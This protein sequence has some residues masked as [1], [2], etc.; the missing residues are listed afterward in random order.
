M[1]NYIYYIIVV[2]AGLAVGS[3]LNVLVL[4]FDQFET[5]LVTRSRCPHCKK[6]IKWY[7]LVPF[8][9]Y[10]YLGAKCR[11]C[12]KPI[13]IQYP[14]VEGLTGLVFGLI[15]W[16]FGLSWSALLLAFSSSLLIAVATYDILNYEMPDVLSYLALIFGLGFVLVNLSSQRMLTWSNFTSYVY[17]FLVGGGF[18]ALLVTISREKWMGAGDIVIGATMGILVGWPNILLGLFAAF[19]AGSIIGLV[20]LALKKKTIKDAVP[21]GLFLVLGT[22][23]AVFWGDKI[24]NWY[25]GIF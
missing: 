4:R 24:V 7:D 3:F 17:A 5:I 6:E 1:G 8:V 12:Q 15:Y 23:V 21:F 9:S 10:I 14:I 2:I 16:K 20:L 13:S 11:Y 18:L 25:L 22:F 19:V